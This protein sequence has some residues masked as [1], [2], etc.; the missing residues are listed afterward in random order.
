MKDNESLDEYYERLDNKINE[1]ESY[2][3]GITNRCS[4]QNLTCVFLI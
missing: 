1:S 3:H 2:S 4:R